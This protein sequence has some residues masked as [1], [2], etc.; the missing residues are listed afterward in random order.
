MLLG[1]YSD[2]IEARLSIP[3][4]YIYS[5]SIVARDL[6]RALGGGDGPKLARP[7]GPRIL[8]KGPRTAVGPLLVVDI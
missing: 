1:F 3:L 2:Y 5:K 4:Y 7:S 8:Y 6:V